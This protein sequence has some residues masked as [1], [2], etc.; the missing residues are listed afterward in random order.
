[1]NGYGF[2]NNI[3]G[4]LSLSKIIGGLNKTLGLVNQAIPLYTQ[5]KPIFSN[6]K[7]LMKVVDIIN[8]PDVK[9]TSTTNK[10]VQNVVATKKVSNNNLP[11]FFQ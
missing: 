11:T 6:A 9:V 3:L 5:L 10:I 7:S 2:G 4:G 8:K 1:M